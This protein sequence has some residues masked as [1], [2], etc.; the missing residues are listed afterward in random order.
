MADHL[1]TYTLDIHEEGAD[2]IWAEVKELPGCFA[3]GFTM[4]EL[5]EC[6]EEAISLYLSEEGKAITAR[7]ASDGEITRERRRFELCS[8]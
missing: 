1:V 7:R 6:L 2:G 3:S 4:D 8:A 5:Y